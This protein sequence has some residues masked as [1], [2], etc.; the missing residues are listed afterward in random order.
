MLHSFFYWFPL[1]FANG[2]KTNLFSYANTM[3]FFP[4]AFIRYSPFLISANV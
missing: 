3:L 4:N 1:F 2:K